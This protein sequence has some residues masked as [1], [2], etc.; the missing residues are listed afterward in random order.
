MALVVKNLATNAGDIRDTSSIPGSGRS[1][2]GGHGNPLQYSCLE[3]PVDRGTWWAIVHWVTKSQTWM[4]WRSTIGI[5]KISTATR[6]FPSGSSDKEPACQSMR[7]K[8]H[9]FNP[10]VGKIP[11]RRA[12]AT[13]SNILAWRIPHTEEPG[14]PQSIGSQESVTIEAM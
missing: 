6:N 14:R 3:N 4:K 5:L 10:W 1:P 11:W 13:H 2:G 7:H 12:W 9:K 8:R